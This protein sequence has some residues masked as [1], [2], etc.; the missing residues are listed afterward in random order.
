MIHPRRRLQELERLPLESVSAPAGWASPASTRNRLVFPAPFRPR[1]P[2]CSPRSIV[3]VTLACGDVCPY[4]SLAVAMSVC[5]PSVTTGVPDV[6]GALSS[7]A[8]IF[9]VDSFE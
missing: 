1:M 6:N 7:D 8:V 5:V 9:A 4:A 3:N 2:Q